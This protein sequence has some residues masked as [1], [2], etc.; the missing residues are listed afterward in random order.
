MEVLLNNT[1]VDKAA[2][3]NDK[4]NAI[5]WACGGGHCDV[6]VE[7]LERGY[8]GGFTEDF[9]GRTPLAWAIQ[10]DAADTIQV[11]I[12]SKPYENK[13]RDRAVRTTL[14]QAWI[15]NVE[16]FS[17]AGVDPQSES[18]IIHGAL[19]YLWLKGLAEVI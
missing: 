9:D 6:F 12:N 14:C 1:A 19:R 4:R 11:L 7:L 8:Q 17:D 15:N 10:K 3:D 16:L 18:N 2:I 13:R 5:S